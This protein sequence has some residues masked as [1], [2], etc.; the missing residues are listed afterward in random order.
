MQ[1]SSTGIGRWQGIGLLVTTMLGTGVF[2]LP[3]LTLQQ[4]GSLALWSWG[5][6]VIAMLPITWV[7]A[8]LGQHYPHAGGPAQFVEQ[9]FSPHQG[10]IIGLLFL[11]LVP[12]GAPAA[13]ELT[14]EFVKLMIPVTATN[15]LL[16]ELLLVVTILLLNWRGI[17]ASGIWQTALTVSM[18]VIVVVLL[19]L[20]HPATSMPVLVES[21]DHA[22]AMVAAFGLAMW[23]FIGIETMTHLVNDFKNPDRDFQFAMITGLLLVGLIYLGCTWLLLSVPIADGLSMSV[24]MDEVFGAGGRWIIG[25]IGTL[26]GLATVNVYMASISRL[27]WSLSQQGVLPKSLS[28]L[29]RHQIPGNALISQTLIIAMVLIMS[30]MLQLHYDVLIRWTNGVIVVIYLMSMISAWRLLPKYR[31]PALAG[32]LV[33][34]LFAWSLGLYMLYALLLWGSLQL[35]GLPLGR[36]AAQLE[37]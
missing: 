8:I 36:Q 30:G 21:T 23:S 9:A 32:G 16:V 1:Q 27:M 22:D 26:S 34:L 5:L 4:A 7:F 20:H 3:Q 19:I 31:L 10:R 18:L 17:R 12:I 11:L 29:N 13:I 14:M 37:S 28:R 15:Q 35:F 24:V 2:V 6:L 33:C 25:I